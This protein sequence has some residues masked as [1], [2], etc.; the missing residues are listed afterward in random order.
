VPSGT[1]RLAHGLPAAVALRGL[2]TFAFFGTDAYVSYTVTSARHASLA[3]GGLAL[4]AATLT[5]T[6]GSW[7]Q[8]RWV[9]QIGPRR[10]VRVGLLAIACGI[11]LMIAVA[12]SRLPTAAAVLAWGVGGLGMGI[13]YSPISLVVLAEAPAGG[14]GTATAA[15]QLC[16]T[17]GI[18]LGTGVAGAIVGTGRLSPAFASCA[19][20]AVL[21]SFAAVRLPAAITPASSSA[22]SA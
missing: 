10:L 1:V 8:A 15:L 2:T 9:H 21:A 6:T 4:T 16:D 22:R 13:T 14:E 17:L 11:G 12:E 19:I 3:L 5:W 20:V 7:I 18:A